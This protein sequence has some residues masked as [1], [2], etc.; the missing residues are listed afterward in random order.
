MQCVKKHSING[1]VSK[2][3]ALELFA[4]A[5]GRQLYI[6]M[7]GFQAISEE[8]VPLGR[9]AGRRGDEVRERESLQGPRSRVGD[10]CN[11]TKAARRP[12]IV[13]A[14]ALHL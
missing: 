7:F 11:A 4:I 2:R 9:V 1:A 10:G 5:M 6:M 3:K 13:S 8:T 12:L 14:C